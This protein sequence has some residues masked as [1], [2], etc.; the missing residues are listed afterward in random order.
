MPKWL[1]IS[2]LS[3]LIVAGAVL[4]VHGFFA[5]PEDPNASDKDIALALN[6]VKAGD[7]KDFKALKDLADKAR[8]D[9]V[10]IYLADRKRM[11]QGLKFESRQATGKGLAELPSGVK[12]KRIKITEK[13]AYKDRS[14]DVKLY[15]Y[16]SPEGSAE[17]KVAGARYGFGG[18]GR[19]KFSSKCSDDAALS[20]ANDWMRRYESKDFV[21]CAKAYDDIMERSFAAD[22]AS[23]PPNPQAERRIADRFEEGGSLNVIGAMNA[24]DQSGFE[25]MAVVFAKIKDKRSQLVFVGLVRDGYWGGEKSP[26]TPCNVWVGKWQPW[27]P[28]WKSEE[29]C[30]KAFQAQFSPKDGKP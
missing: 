20:I 14:F 17:T 5:P 19:P 11:E 4:A 27:K 30:L 24:P 21:F 1:K 22:Y 18:G 13:W 6:W 12:V 3:L 10:D 25:S 15:I 29:D 23:L 28:E 2:L 8:Q 9:I 16:L 7:A 26:W